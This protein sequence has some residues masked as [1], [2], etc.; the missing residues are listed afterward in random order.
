MKRSALLLAFIIGI[1]GLIH[2]QMTDTSM[3]QEPQQQDSVQRASPVKRA[4]NQLSV[5]QDKLNLNLNQ[6]TQLRMILLDEYISLDSLKSHP[7]GNQ[8]SDAQSRRAI[9]QDA[10][11]KTYALQT[12]EQRLLYAM[13]KL[14]QKAK[15]WERRRNQ[16]TTGNPSANG[17]P[18]Q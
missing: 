6:V 3:Y 11:V 14:E 7:S 1:N 2:A 8:K 18:Q 9:L 10:D 16:A 15:A 5:L 4:A 12:D 13:W 17:T